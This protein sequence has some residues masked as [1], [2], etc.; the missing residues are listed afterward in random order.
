MRL[1]PMA[2]PQPRIRIIG[3]GLS[4]L[5]LAH[6]LRRSGLSVS[7]HE[8]A[9][10]PQAPDQGYRIH[11]NA[12]SIAALRACLPEKLFADFLLL[13]QPLGEGF[14]FFDRKLAPIAFLKKRGAPGQ[15]DESRG[16]GRYP[17]RQL[18][19]RGL[20][21]DTHFGKDFECCSFGDGD[22]VAAHF[23]DGSSAAG[24]LLIGADGS[25]SAVVRDRLPK[26]AA[27]D[28]GFS[29]IIGKV[30]SD[31]LPGDLLPPPPFDHVGLV[32][33]P[34]RLLTFLSEQDPS[35]TN[36]TLAEARPDLA[37]VI[38]PA[39]DF[40]VWSL[41]V[42]TADLPWNPERHVGGEEMLAAA[43]RIA[44]NSPERLQK[45]IARTRPDDAGIT[46]LWSSPTGVD[47]PT[48]PAWTMLGDAIHS[49]VPLRGLGAS[50]AMIDA[51]HLRRTI[52]ARPI[53]GAGWPEALADYE[54]AMRRRNA[55]QVSSSKR[56]LSIARTTGPPR[57]LFFT[58]LKI[59][60][61]WLRWRNG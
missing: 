22:P 34:G 42:P 32:V 41:V 2:V 20:E 40:S 7:V 10:S 44:G 54:R 1:N 35:D 31:A 12:P 53:G 23:A 17:L 60:S 28:S 9:E 51:D 13:S 18:L 29:A 55:G 49:M 30:R 25:T 36:R 26:A 46:T 27:R 48:H 8:K 47:W 37:P 57:S 58:G 19:L 3:A 39:V 56:L 14:T 5:T 4:G 61:A 50:A 11:L 21:A 38:D 45:L 59:G 16:I 33:G 6:G 52:A 24:D 43:C 15:D